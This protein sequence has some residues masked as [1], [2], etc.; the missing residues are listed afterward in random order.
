MNNRPFQKLSD[1]YI[2][3]LKLIASRTISK[4]REPEEFNSLTKTMLN[5]LHTHLDFH[6]GELQDIKA[7]KD[8]QNNNGWVANL[9][10]VRVSY[11]R[12]HTLAQELLDEE[13][14][15]NRIERKA[16]FRA[17]LFRFLTTIF[18]GFG[19]ILVYF[20][21]QYFGINM[22]LLKVSA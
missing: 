17:L 20:T 9:G 8:N 18:I 22:P 21:A 6:N 2:A 1:R 19:V 13:K 3:K 12:I 16:H 11:K 5:N 10:E 4:P 15:I 14:A 7:Q